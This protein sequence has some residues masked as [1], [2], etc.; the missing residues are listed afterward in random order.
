MDKNEYISEADRYDKI[1]DRLGHDQLD[2]FKFIKSQLADWYVALATTCFAIA[3]VSL[4]IGQNVKKHPL[5]F[6]WATALLIANGIFIFFIR[7]LELESE[8]S[9]FNKLKQKEAD[10]WTMSKV[11]REYAGGDTRRGGMFIEAANRFANDYQKSPKPFTRLE[12]V[13][14]ITRSCFLDL[15]FGLLL[16]PVL[17]LAPQLPN[18]LHISFTVYIC[19]L[20]IG[21]VLY[22]FYVI[23]QVIKVIKEK[24][25]IDKADQQ[26]RDEVYADKK[27]YMQ[28]QSDN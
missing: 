21:F 16:F 19:G 5:L 15:A 27:N 4:S 20:W 9:S 2:N 6:G 22:A 14:F 28:N 26:I 24:R 11:A 10:L 12:W 3:G 25:E 23:L 17:M 18:S 7:K 13:K 8:S 1:R